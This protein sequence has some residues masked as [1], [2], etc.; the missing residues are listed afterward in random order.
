MFAVDIQAIPRNPEELFWIQFRFNIKS[1]Y[2][3]TGNPSY[4]S[5]GLFQEHSIIS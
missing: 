4:N 2:Y 5:A 1:G 3:K